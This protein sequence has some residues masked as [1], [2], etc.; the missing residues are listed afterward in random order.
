[1]C[2]LINYYLFIINYFCTTR[3]TETSLGRGRLARECAAKAQDIIVWSS[4][5]DDPTAGEPPA[6]QVVSSR[7][8][9]ASS[10]ALK[11]QIVQKVQGVFFT[12][13]PNRPCVSLV[14]LRDS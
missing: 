9:T 2:S 14:V 12:I 7:S 10:A 13:V 1:M 6:S 4:V 11:V 8:Q 3:P 5:S